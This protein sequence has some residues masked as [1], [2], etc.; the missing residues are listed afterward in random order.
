MNIEMGCRERR[1]DMTQAD[2]ECDGEAGRGRGGN[3]GEQ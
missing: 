2:G 3:V 1:E